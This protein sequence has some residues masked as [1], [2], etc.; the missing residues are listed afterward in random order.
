MAILIVGTG[1]RKKGRELASLVGSLGL[2]VLTLADVNDPLDVEETGATFAENAR[3]KASQQAIHLGQWVLADD[4]GLAVDALGGGPSVQS[5]RYSGPGAT[6]ESNR[7]KLLA[8]LN[9]VRPEQRTAQFICHLTLCDPTGQIRAESDGRCSGRII[10]EE[11]G[12]HGFGYDPLFEIVEYHRTFAELGDAVKSMLSHR[13][14]AVQRLLPELRRLL[15]HGEWISQAAPR[16]ARSE[17]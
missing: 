15:D 14:R 16:E 6:D 17:R 4:S 13:A 8:E 2:E 5:A 12:E 9:D 10:F 11:R 7:H 3:L 1:N